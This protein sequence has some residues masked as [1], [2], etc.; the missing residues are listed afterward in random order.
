MG[1][2]GEQK[3]LQW[4]FAV[5]ISMAHPLFYSLNSWKCV[6]KPYDTPLRKS[7]GLLRTLV[8]G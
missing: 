4:N 6:A 5:L 8:S 2:G 3:F 7:Q 1:Q